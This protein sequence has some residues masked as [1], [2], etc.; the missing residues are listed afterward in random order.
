MF[1]DAEKLHAI[2]K[3]NKEIEGSGYV[4]KTNKRRYAL[5]NDLLFS[6]GHGKK[7]K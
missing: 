2:G 5:V 7:N 4:F 6:N 3:M 1:S